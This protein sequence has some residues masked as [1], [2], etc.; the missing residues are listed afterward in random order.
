MEE[1]Q[2]GYN[3]LYDLSALTGHTARGDSFSITTPCARHHRLAGRALE[4]LD[5]SYNDLE[6]PFAA[7]R[8][9]TQL[10]TLNI[11]GNPALTADM[12]R[13]AAGGSPRLPDHHGHRPLHAGADART[14][15]GNTAALTVSV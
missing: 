12:V 1:L 4:E 11:T 5:L 6:L 8:S 3:N 10:R 7:L 14:S 2:L 15:R 13:F 9:L